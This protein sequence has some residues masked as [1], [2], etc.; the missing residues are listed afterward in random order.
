MEA[1]SL[2]AAS[3]AEVCEEI[4]VKNRQKKLVERKTY[5]GRRHGKRESESCAALDCK[6]MTPFQR[7]SQREAAALAMTGRCSV[8]TSA[9]WR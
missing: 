7:S 5:T 6:M 1:S 3:S 9:E 4:K 2:F 8:P